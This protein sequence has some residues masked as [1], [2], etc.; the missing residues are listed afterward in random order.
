MKIK[1]STKDQPSYRMIQSVD[2]EVL[3][4]QAANY[5]R[6]DAAD[7]TRKRGRLR[8]ERALVIELLHRYGG[9][10]QRMIGER[11][12]GL[13]EGLVSRD[14]RAIR[15]KIENEPKIRKWFQDLTTVNT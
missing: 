3:I 6:L 12:G 7:L 10:K 5:F 14:C 13:D 11:F 2:G 9:L 4:K 15:A 1:G 8:Q